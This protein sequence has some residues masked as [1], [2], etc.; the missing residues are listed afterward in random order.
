MNLENLLKYDFAKKFVEGKLNEDGFL[1]RLMESVR[2]DK[3]FREAT[4]IISLETEALKEVVDTLKTHSKRTHPTR[5]S[6]LG[7]F[8]KGALAASA[9][10]SKG[11]DRQDV[12]V[13][14]RVLFNEIL[15]ISKLTPAKMPV[16]SQNINTP[17]III[18]EDIHGGKDE[19]TGWKVEFE[20]LELLRQKFGFNFV[21]LEGWAGKWADIKRRREIL[22]G[23]IELIKYLLNDSNYSLLG[24]EDAELQIKTLEISLL[25]DYN[26]LSVLEDVVI[27]RVKLQGGLREE[28]ARKIITQVKEKTVDLK[29]KEIFRKD[30]IEAWIKTYVLV[31]PKL[32]GNT[33]L[34]RTL[35][36]LSLT[37]IKIA[38]WMIVLYNIQYF[39]SRVL[40]AKYRELINK[41][42][43]LERTM[44]KE[45]IRNLPIFEDVTLHQREKFAV[46]KML[47]VMKKFRKTVGIIV[48]GK[49]HTNGLIK[50]FLKQAGD[51]NINIIVLQEFHVD[52]T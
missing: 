2:T 46:S 38:N 4:E 1:A 26:D 16:A 40:D 3:K 22:N 37:I 30:T 43:F 33:D 45:S 19:K 44:G 9:I 14:A 25:A 5:R 47:E 39:S 50:E 29:D 24:L 12:Y 32:V 27:T 8:G 23:E 48:F 11:D 7:W 41:Y 10:T 52:F 20:R 21:G 42:K 49:Y 34:I 35:L 18:I 28:D 51:G 15:K 31:Y 17:T 13:N 36:N 6:F